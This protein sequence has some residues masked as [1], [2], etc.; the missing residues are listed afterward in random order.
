[1]QFPNFN[2]LFLGLAVICVAATVK[3]FARSWAPSF[4]R[5][6]PLAALLLAIL[7][8]SPYQV[9]LA[10]TQTHPLFIFLTVAALALAEK[11]RPGLAGAALAVACAVKITPGLIFVYWIF[12]GRRPAAVWFAVW[13]AVLLGLTLLLTGEEL[14]RAYLESM[15]RVSGLMI[16]YFNNQ[17]LAAFLFH[18]EEIQASLFDLDLTPPLSFGLKALSLTLA[19]ASAAAAGWLARDKTRRAEAI[20]LALIGMTIFIPLAWS[21]YFIVL[22][23]AAM[24]LWARGDRWSRAVCLGALLLNS[25]PLAVNP[26]TAETSS[27]TLIHSHFLSAVLM[28][29]ALALGPALSGVALRRRAAA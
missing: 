7:L 20:S 22:I 5:P 16:Y 1:M 10:L 24:T 8:S 11:N 23:P 12:A 14:T 4:L 29:A 25:P 19:L 28:G 26:F 18:R 15:R 13:S 17:S 2:L 6:G 3:I 21:H 9:A 27:V